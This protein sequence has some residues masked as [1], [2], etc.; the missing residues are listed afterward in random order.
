MLC[1]EFNFK[2]RPIIFWKKKIVHRDEGSEGG[3]DKVQ[4]GSKRRSKSSS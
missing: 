3:L 4:M 1:S 2:S